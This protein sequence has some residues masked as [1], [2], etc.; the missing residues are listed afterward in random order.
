MN[1][2][3]KN[4]INNLKNARLDSFLIT[5]DC[6][7]R[8]LTGF[9]SS[10]S[11]LLVSRRKVFYITDGRYVSEAK[12]HLNG[13]EVRCFKKTMIDSVYEILKAQKSRRV[14][15]DSRHLSHFLYNK[16]EEKRPKQISF[17]E[18]N[19]LIE[20]MR[21]IK[22]SEEILK[23]KKALQI[24][25]KTHQ[26]LKKIIQ[27]GVSEREIALQLEQFIKKEGA[28]FSFPPIVAS[29]PNS[30]YPHAQITS[31]KL[32]KNDVI[33]VDIGIDVEGYKSDL[34]RM[35]FLGRIPPLVKDIYRIVQEVQ[36]IAIGEI[37][38]GVKANQVDY[39]ARKYLKKHKLDKL[40]IHSL[41]HGVG[42]EV[43]EAPRLSAKSAAILKEGMVLTVEPGV[44]LPEQFGIRIEDMVLVRKDAVEELSDN[45]N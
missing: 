5:N 34:T 40:F 8:Y 17:I 31:R 4:Y 1:K 7:I 27:P 44:Y 23:I 28:V 11:W 19:G 6:N 20:E 21:Q 16:L 25:Q 12:K 10:E 30:S 15:F 13:I 45:I 43:H 33:L 9:E 22:T 18:C 42:L 38:D 26:Y 29:G 24:H 36:R 41:G 37:R 3:I 39:L 2:N 35:F 32:Q 14:G